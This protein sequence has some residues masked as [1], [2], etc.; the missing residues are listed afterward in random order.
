MEKCTYCIQRVQAGK[1][2]ARNEGRRVEDGEIQSACQVAC[3]TQAIVFGDLKDPASRVT[4]LQKDHRNYAMLE[5][6]NI[7]PRTLYLARVRNIHQRLKTADQLKTAEAHHSTTSESGEG[8]G[9]H[10]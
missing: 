10:S 8:H 5:E 4:R 6:L 2:T 7:K 1:I 3:P 9:E